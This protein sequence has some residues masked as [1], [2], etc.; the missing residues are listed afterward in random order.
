M[1]RHGGDTITA[2]QQAGISPRDILDFS[3]NISPLG[4]PETVR[5]ALVQGI[6]GV[7]PYPDPACRD[8]CKKISCAELVDEA[9]VLCGNGA[10]ELI[11]AIAH[12]LK[13]KKALVAAPSFSE[14]ALALRSAGSQIQWF[15]TEPSKGFSVTEAFLDE[16]TPELSLVFLANPSNPVGNIIEQP[17]LEAIAA[18]CLRTHTCLVI[19]EC[20]L[21]FLPDGRRRSL[22]AR[23]AENP[24]L[25]VLKSFTKMYAMA[26]IRLG[27][28]LCASPSLRAR[29]AAAMPPWS[30][31]TLAQAA[32]IAALESGDYAERVRA[33]VAGERTFLMR[34]LS[35]LSLQ[36][37]DSRAN[38][39]FFQAGGKPDLKKELLRSGIL[40]R[41]CAN[42]PGLGDGYYRIAV[43][44]HSENQKL[45][46]AM[47]RCAD[48]RKIHY[49][50]G[51]DV[52][53]GQEHHCRR[54]VQ[55]AETGRISRR[56]I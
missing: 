26:G 40:I 39:I 21:D 4:L 38:F 55:A 24:G 19:D 12:G 14:Y 17:L 35:A 6:G 43:R 29:V 51:D 18:K 41:S 54:A 46:Q 42:Y 20:F 53:C 36:V 10:A 11:F 2:A 49:D 32:G 15:R 22:V 7:V 33:L 25:I 48:E 47:R 27:Y 30:V 16:I 52:K 3:S 28:L 31:S 56:P 50:S 5:H 23:L 44:V 8:L 13:P 9:M 1:E 37:Y 45:L 34:E